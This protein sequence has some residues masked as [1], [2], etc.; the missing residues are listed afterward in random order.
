MKQRMPGRSGVGLTMQQLRFSTSTFKMEVVGSFNP[1][2]PT[3]WVDTLYLLSLSILSKVHPQI[4][5]L[6]VPDS[7]IQVSAKEVVYNLSLPDGM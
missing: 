3:L 7:N 1:C 5:S 6:I 2:P 4:S